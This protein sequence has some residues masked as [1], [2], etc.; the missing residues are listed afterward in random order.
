MPTRT[1]TFRTYTVEA[2]RGEYYASATELFK[3]AAATP[4]FVAAKTFTASDGEELTVVEFASDE[5]LNAWRSN[6]EHRAAQKSSGRFFADYRITVFGDPI[7]DY[8]V[9]GNKPYRK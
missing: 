4:G 5:A 3:L 8:G 7:R 1:V 9:A 6:A 2:A